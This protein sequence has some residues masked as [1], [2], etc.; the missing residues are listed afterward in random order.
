MDLTSKKTVINKSQK[1]SFEFLSDPANFK[2]LMPE[3]TKKFEPNDEGGFLFQLSGMP[4]IGLKLNEK[5]PDER[6][7]WG[8]ASDKF[9]FTLTSEVAEVSEHESEVQFIFHGDFN[10]MMAMMVKNPLKKFIDTLS[11]NLSTI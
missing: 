3:S 1:E 9:K 10:P 4:E 7:V 8:S 11:D 6:I 2:R 5:Q